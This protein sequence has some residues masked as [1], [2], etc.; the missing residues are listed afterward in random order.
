MMAS[1]RGI[2][3]LVTIL[4]LIGGGFYLF[5]R[6]D[7]PPSPTNQNQSDTDQLSNPKQ[8]IEGTPDTNTLKAGGSSYS[9]PQGVYV[10]L[11]PNDYTLDSQ[12][13]D[14]HV[15]I[16]KRGA[17]QQGQTE[18]YDG[19]IMVFEAINLQ[20]QSLE[21]LVDSRIKESTSDGNSTLIKPKEAILLKDYLGFTFETQGFGGAT[22]LI[23][24]KNP[25]STTALSITFSVNDPEK[26]NYQ[27]EVN[28]ILSTLELM[29]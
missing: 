12:N 17:T 23:L 15:R 5:A 6:R 4:V 26:K 3:I 13:N 14:V 29:K 7:N 2:V 11:Y 20:D 9:N 1:T 22:H 24:Q 28:A 10:F 21:S 18:I 25:D 27:S 16:S 19:V 8:F